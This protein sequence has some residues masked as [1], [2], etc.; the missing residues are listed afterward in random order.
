MNKYGILEDESSR[1]LFEKINKRLICGKCYSD[2]KV[3]ETRDQKGHG[4]RSNLLPGFSSGKI[5]KPIDILIVAE[6]HG[7]G[8]PED[9]RPQKDLDY[10]VSWLGD[11]YLESPLKRFHQQQVRNLLNKLSYAGKTWVFTDLIKCFVWHGSNSELNGRDNWMIA[12]RHCSGYLEEQMSLLQPHMVLGLGGTVAQY[13]KLDKPKHGSIHGVSINGNHT[14][15][16]HSLFPTQW[17]AD[18]WVSENGW[19]LVIPKLLV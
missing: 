19:E 9:F 14:V 13:F 5:D 12:I 6:A 16:V 2:R 8:R 3:F 17:T 10:E 11:Y 1:V 15:Y 7:G 4:C 18:R